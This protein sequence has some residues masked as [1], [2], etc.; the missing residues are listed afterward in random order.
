MPQDTGSRPNELPWP[1]LIYSGALLV[2]WT[3]ERFGPWLWLDTAMDSLPRV[4]GSVVFGLGLGLDLWAIVTLRRH[5]TTVLPHAGATALVTSGPYR[6]SRNPIYLGNTVALI[7]LAL[8]L[9]WGWL[10]LLVPVTVTAVGWLA[11]SREEDHLARRFPVEWRA[12]A[13]KVRRWL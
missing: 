12:Y 13:E 9:R 11:V 10:L 1:P 6:F 8:L 4:F 3:L 7:G 5:R 2:A